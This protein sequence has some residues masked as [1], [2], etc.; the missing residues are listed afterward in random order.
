MIFTGSRKKGSHGNGIP[1]VLQSIPSST[2]S[3]LFLQ[4][5]G[6]LLQSKERHYFSRF[7][8]SMV[9]SHHLQLRCLPQLYDNFKLFKIKAATSHHSVTQKEVDELLAIGAFRLLTSG[10]VF[11]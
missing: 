6:T 11:F 10:V 5:G 3:S 9:K 7:V 1:D 4:G 8:L 2:S